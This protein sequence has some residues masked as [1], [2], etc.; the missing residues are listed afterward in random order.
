MSDHKLAITILEGE[1][2]TSWQCTHQKGSKASYLNIF[3]ESVVGK[4][5]KCPHEVI[6]RCLCVECK[7]LKKIERMLWKYCLG[8]EICGW[9]QTHTPKLHCVVITEY[10]SISPTFTIH[11]VHR[12]YTCCVG[13]SKTVY[14]RVGRLNAGGYLVGTSFPMMT[15]V[16]NI[17]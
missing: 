17:P 4:P 3:R 9:P 13:N 7:C 15:E 16:E 1:K 11:D 14:P 12:I 2:E 6:C 5:P 10:G 8:S